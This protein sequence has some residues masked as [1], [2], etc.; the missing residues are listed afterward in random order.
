MVELFRGN[1][2]L[3]VNTPGRPARLPMPPRFPVFVFRDCQIW[4][5]FRPLGG[6]SVNQHSLTSNSRVCTSN[7]QP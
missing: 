6:M 2:L 5:T 4:S 3:W 7:I 1:A